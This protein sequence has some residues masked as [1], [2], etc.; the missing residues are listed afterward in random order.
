MREGIRPHIV[1][2]TL[3][4]AVGCISDGRAPSREITPS[5]VPVTDCAAKQAELLMSPLTVYSAPDTNSLVVATLEKGESIYRCERS[6]GWVGI[7][8]SDDH[9]DCL[10][11]PMDRKCPSGWT[12]HEPDSIATD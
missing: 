10:T 7:W 3:L 9:A 6:G 12:N 2:G 5:P 1:G 11:R 4:L 8:F